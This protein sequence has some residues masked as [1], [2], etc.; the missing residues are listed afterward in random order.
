VG[1]KTKRN[2]PEKFAWAFRIE[3]ERAWYESWTL[4]NHAVQP[5]WLRSTGIPLVRELPYELC[6]SSL[7]CGNLR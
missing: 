1:F 6:E 3:D 5:L 4:F 7:D 2:G